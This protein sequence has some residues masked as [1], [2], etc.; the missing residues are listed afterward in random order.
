MTSKLLI[1]TKEEIP[2]CTPEKIFSHINQTGKTI[3]L[4]S[5]S[6]D[7]GLTLKEIRVLSNKPNSNDYTGA[8]KALGMPD[9]SIKL[10]NPHGRFDYLATSGMAKKLLLDHADTL[11]KPVSSLT[12]RE[13]RESPLLKH[14]FGMK[15]NQTSFLLLDTGA[16][17]CISELKNW[18]KSWAES[19]HAQKLYQK[20]KT[21]LNVTSEWPSCYKIRE[22]KIGTKFMD[23]FGNSVESMNEFFSKE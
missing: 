4:K 14:L 20:L 7:L 15:I 11:G 3:S 1:S 13:I 8:M 19:P 6:E 10:L 12:Q 18:P 23:Q 17:S 5:I 16:V 2:G 21:E 9:E 22:S